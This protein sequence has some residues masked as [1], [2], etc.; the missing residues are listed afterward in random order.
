MILN[1]PQKPNRGG[2]YPFDPDFSIEIT[3]NANSWNPCQIPWI[4]TE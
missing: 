1:L 3:H 4:A 2:D